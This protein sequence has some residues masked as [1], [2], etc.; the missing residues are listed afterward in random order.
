M[1]PLI[2]NGTCNA[3]CTCIP[4]TNNSAEVPDCQV[5]TW[6]CGTKIS[7]IINGKMSTEFQNGENLKQISRKAASHLEPAVVSIFFQI[8]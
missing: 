6:L 1:L 2:E 7:Y 8:C 5:A 4:L 3:P